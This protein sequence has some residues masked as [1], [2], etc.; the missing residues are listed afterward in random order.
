MRASKNESRW[1]MSQDML[2]VH[3]RTGSN[4]DQKCI[5]GPTAK[6]HN[7]AGEVHEKRAIAALNE[8]TCSLSR[9][10]EPECFKSPNIEQQVC[11]SNFL[12]KALPL[13]GLAPSV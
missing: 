6:D 3:L 11:R 4:V 5:R 8:W 10:V 12:T 1:I 9:G 7:F 13:E 2:L